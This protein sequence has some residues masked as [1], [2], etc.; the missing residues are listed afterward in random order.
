MAENA[1]VM[2][3]LRELHY[4]P[5]LDEDDEMYIW[6]QMKK[7]YFH[8]NEAKDPN[9]V[10]MWLDKVGDVEKGEELLYL[11]ACNRATREMKSLKYY[12]DEEMSEVQV[13]IGFYYLGPDSLRYAI[14]K[15]LALMGVACR[16]YHMVLDKLRG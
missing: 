1:Y 5:Q 11:T 9:Y 10:N 3:A 6:Y 13:N 15:Y 7:V 8:V 4:V 14:G 16:E 12:L 2:N